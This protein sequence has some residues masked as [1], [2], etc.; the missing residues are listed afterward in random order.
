[1]AVLLATG[2]LSIVPAARLARA[3]QAATPDAKLVAEFQ[4][5]VKAYVDLHDRLEATL[6]PL[7]ERPRPEQVEQHQRALEGLISR[8][9]TGAKPGD[10]FTD[11]VRA[12]FRRQLARLD[13]RT[14]QSI[15]DENPRTIRLRVNGRY[16]E[17]VPL[18]NM[19]PKVLL[20]LPPLPPELEFRFVGSRLVLL[21]T[22]ADMVVD[23]I[24][25]A[26][27]I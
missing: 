21:D 10:V 2:L 14:V 22:H 1:L 6:P 18:T 23:F 8:A 11:E 16:P 9:R 26:I 7:P 13:R 17:G 4:E 24:D 19:P 27:T 3:E 5:R 25:N 15:M 12:Y 20:V